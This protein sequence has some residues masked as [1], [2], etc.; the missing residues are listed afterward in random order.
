MTIALDIKTMAASV[1]GTQCTPA[2]NSVTPLFTPSLS[3]CLSASLCGFT[4][5]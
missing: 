1:P 5:N 4:T 3:S 2:L